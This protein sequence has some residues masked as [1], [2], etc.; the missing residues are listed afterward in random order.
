MIDRPV[1]RPAELEVLANLMLGPDRSAPRLPSPSSGGPLASL[2]GA[3]LRALERPPCFVS[4]SGGRDSSAVLALATRLARRHGLAV[5]VPAIMRFP[6]AP[7]SDEADWQRAV[8]DHLGLEDPEVV[9]LTDELD[10]LG[11]AATEVLSRHGLLWPANAYMHVP[12]LELARGGTVLT[13]IGGDELFSTRAPRRAGR[14]LAAALLPRPA[15]EARWRRRHL[16]EG[17][18]WL[19]RQAGA[20]VSRALAREEFRGPYR[21]D[22]ALRH[23]YASRAFG[24]LDGSLRVIGAAREVTVV[25]PLIEPHV[26]ADLSR[27]AGR[28]GF[29]SRSQAMAR[30]FGDLLP[31]AVL[32]RSTKAGFGRAVWGPATREFAQSWSGVGADPEQVDVD[33]LR[34]ELSRPEPD[35]RI[36]LLVHHVWLNAQAPSPAS[37]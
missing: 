15:R 17:Y 25:N 18:A 4:F 19:T 33:A 14:Q 26:L 32:S 35:A 20:R 28:R 7:A 37:S 29:S 8:L 13:G 21:W 3:V 31:P 34:G 24:A 27:L 23:W 5:P 36:I 10:A 11:P 12:L 1:P 6:G 22:A 2:E 30:L 16:P 9:T